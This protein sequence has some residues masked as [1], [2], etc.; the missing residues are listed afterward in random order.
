MRRWPARAWWFAV[1]L[2]CY[3]VSVSAPA[4]GGQLTVAVAANFAAPMKVIASQFESEHGVTLKIAYGATGQFYAQIRNGAP[5]EVLLAGDVATP[6]KL[7]DEG[8]ALAQ[9]QFTYAIGQL[10]LWSRDPELIDTDAAVLRSPHFRRLALANPVLSPY[11]AAAIEVMT[12]LGLRQS[13]APK[14]VQGANIGQAFQF[15]AS[16][17]AQLGFVAMAQVFADGQLTSGSAWVV[18]SQY[19][20]PIEQDAVVLVAGAHNPTAH[21]LLQHLASPEGVEVLRSFG[22][23]VHP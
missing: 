6:A 23:R 21:A 22:Y 14:L 3:A 5:F 20:A 1:V 13:L 4:H 16:G 17:N 2:W 8:F 19:H 15:V 9:T 18:P 11:G 12:H 10:V 7:V